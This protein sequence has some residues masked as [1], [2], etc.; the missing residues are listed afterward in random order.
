MGSLNSD[1][2]QIVFTS[3]SN[4]EKRKQK[5]FIKQVRAKFGDNS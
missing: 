1:Q 5:I 2:Q 4:P 3:A